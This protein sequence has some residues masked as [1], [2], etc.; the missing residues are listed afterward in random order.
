MKSGLKDSALSRTS[1]GI[2]GLTVM[3]TPMNLADLMRTWMLGF[4]STQQLT[5]RMTIWTLWAIGVWP[6]V[7]SGVSK[8]IYSTPQDSLTIAHSGSVH[9]KVMQAGPCEDR[10]AIES[11]KWDRTMWKFRGRMIWRCAILPFG[12][13]PGCVIGLATI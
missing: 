11:W 13:G 12:Q 9:S 1:A 7:S 10:T 3:K 5:A 4:T 6:D 2:T 8:W